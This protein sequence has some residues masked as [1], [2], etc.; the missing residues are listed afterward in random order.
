MNHARQG[1]SVTLLND[2][3]VLIVGGD[4]PCQGCEVLTSAEIFDPV[5]ETFT[6]TGSMSIERTRHTATLLTDGRVLVIGG[7]DAELCSPDW[8]PPEATLSSAEL[9]DPAT[10]TFGV[11]GSMPDT[12]VLL[13]SATRLP[14]GN[15]L[16]VVGTEGWEGQ[17][18]VIYDVGS[19]SFEPVGDMDSFRGNHAAVALR[20]NQSCDGP[21]MVIGGSRGPISSLSSVELYDLEW[22]RFYSTADL[23]EARAGGHAATLLDDGRVLV[24]GGYYFD[25]DVVPIPLRTASI[26]QPAGSCF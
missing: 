7:R 20:S 26:F 13:N 2:G 6:L 8:A 5:S 25:N 23:P 10:G 11:T 1:F 24:A 9:Y 4:N 18:N 17:K 19:G 22:G 21:I 3:R 15:V 12:G 14:D 16:V